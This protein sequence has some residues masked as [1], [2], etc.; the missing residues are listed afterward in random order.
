MAHELGVE[1][2]HLI[3][4]VMQS[5]FREKSG[6]SGKEEA[7][8][9]NIFC[10]VVEVKEAGDILVLILGVGKKVRNDKVEVRCVELNVFIEL[11]GD[12]TKVP[13]LMYECR[14][15]LQ[16]LEFPWKID[17]LAWDSIDKGWTD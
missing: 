9:I 3:A 8:V 13:Q 5:G 1:V 4:G 14:A 16:S 10:S 12:I 17:V 6:S 2:V 11:L 7:V 15:M